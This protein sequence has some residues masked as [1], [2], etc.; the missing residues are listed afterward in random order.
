M[1]FPEDY[2]HP[3]EKLIFDLKPHWFRLVPASAFARIRR[4]RADVEL[5]TFDAPH[6]LLQTLPDPCAD[7]VVRF[8]EFVR[9]GQAELRER[10]EGK[11]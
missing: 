8:A 10:P 4:V 9:T 6:F 1:A 11:P 7:A 3:N 2:L 5:A